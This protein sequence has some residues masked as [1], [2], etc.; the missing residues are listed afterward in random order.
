[1]FLSFLEY[2]RPISDLLIVNGIAAVHLFFSQRLCILFPSTVI[3]LISYLSLSYS[4][5]Y[6]IIFIM[7]IFIFNAIKINTVSLSLSL[8]ERVI[9]T[10]ESRA[11]RLRDHV[12]RLGLL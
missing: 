10:T 12:K 8:I 3:W 1:M 5:S 4:L 2:L 7:F 9:N 6:D 11:R